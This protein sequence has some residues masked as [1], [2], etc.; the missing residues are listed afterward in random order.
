MTSLAL[1]EP[2]LD[3][4]VVAILRPTSVE[5][6]DATVAALVASG[7]RCLEVTA[8]TPGYLD[9]LTR[10]VAAVPVG[11]AVGLGTV[12]SLAM[13]AP[14]LDAGASFLVTP[15]LVRGLPALAAASGVPTVLG[16]WT[17]SEVIAAVDEGATAVKIF[18]AGSGGVAHLR[19]LREP[20]PDVPFVPSGG[21]TPDDAVDFVRAGAVAVGL[22]SALTGSAL[23]D[24]DMSV[25]AEQ[26]P[27]LLASVAGA[28]PEAVR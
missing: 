14:A 5:H 9:V 27:A 13:A 17:P 24:G 28:R 4:A 12:T 26:A 18:P 20:F 3:T 2:L 23:R 15:G 8:T 25:I 11:V 1:P 6:L 19:H 16:A 7:V 10:L 22:G 21:I